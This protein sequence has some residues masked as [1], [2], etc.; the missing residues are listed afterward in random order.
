ML[1]K[2]VFLKEDFGLVLIF[3]RILLINFLCSY[4]NVFEDFKCRVFECIVYVDDVVL[5]YVC[6]FVSMVKINMKWFLLFGV[7]EENNLKKN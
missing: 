5:F 7:F 4:L 3:E 6:L 1:F 2:C